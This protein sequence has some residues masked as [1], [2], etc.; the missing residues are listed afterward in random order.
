MTRQTAIFAL[1]LV[2]MAALPALAWDGATILQAQGELTH[3]IWLAAT[4]TPGFC[5]WNSDAGAAGFHATEADGY[6][7]MDCPH[8]WLMHCDA[9]SLAFS[10]SYPEIDSANVTGADYGATL[11]CTVEFAVQTRLT[12]LREVAGLL[13]SDVHTA[14]LTWPDGTVL[15]LLTEAPDRTRP[16]WSFRRASTPW[17]STSTPTRRTPPAATWPGMPDASASPGR[18]PARSRSRR[19]PGVRSR[20]CIGSWAPARPSGNGT[21][22]H[23][24][25]A[26]S[27]RGRAAGGADQ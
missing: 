15:P 19:H 6:G 21:K 17:R 25:P 27:R 16:R 24:A 13:S 12:A 9:D 4:P 23:A 8:P 22:R 20:A 18:T 26:A 2:G 7:N 10:G 11:A 14:T 5:Y 1:A 3:D